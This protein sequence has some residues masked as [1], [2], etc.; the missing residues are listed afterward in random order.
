M[1]L[2]PFSRARLF[3][4]WRPISNPVG[5][6]EP[7]LSRAWLIRGSELPFCLVAAFIGIYGLLIANE[8]W[9][10]NRSVAKC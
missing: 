9:D 8:R 1:L 2:L 7:L 10:K 5:F 6:G 4:P 3:F